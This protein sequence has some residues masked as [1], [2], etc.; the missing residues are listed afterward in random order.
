[1]AHET[2]MTGVDIDAGQ[3][4][5]RNINFEDIKDALRLGVADFTAKPSHI[6]FLCLFYPIIGLFLSRLIFGYEVLPWLFPVVAG[7]TLVGPIAAIGLYELS[8]RRE[9]G[10]DISL[11]NVFDVMKSPS[12]RGI[13]ILSIVIAAI[14]VA[15]LFIA[16]LVYSV[17]FDGAVPTSFTGFISDVFT[18][19]QGWTLI[20]VGG[21]IG[22]VIA[23]MVLAISVVSLPMLLDKNVSASQAVQTSVRNASVNPV[24]MSTWGLIVVGLLILGS[25][26][27][28]IGLAVVLPVLGHATWHLYRK[29]VVS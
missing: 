27:F 7:F 17:T 28:F 21:G 4:E 20:V 8:R 10:L 22:A 5:I 26:P 25:I 29:V 14:F 15:W 23:I 18:T 13:A 16:Q 12:I 2:S 9:Q 24:M 1:M 6:F 19:S 3:P 11:W